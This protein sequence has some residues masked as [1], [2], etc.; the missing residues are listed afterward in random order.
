MKTFIAELAGR[1][2]LLIDGSSLYAVGTCQNSGKYFSFYSSSLKHELVPLGSI[3]SLVRTDELINAKEIYEFKRA[4]IEERTNAGFANNNDREKMLADRKVISFIV[5]ELMP[6]MS[7]HKESVEELLGENT[8]IQTVERTHEFSEEELLA[9]LRLMQEGLKRE[10]AEE[11]QGINPEPI[12]YLLKNILSPSPILML[13]RFVYSLTPSLGEAT[14]KIRVT[15][16]EK[17]WDTKAVTTV[18]NLEKKYLAFL[19]NFHRWKA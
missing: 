15:G 11:F 8:P 1:A 9:E 19:D 13:D 7:G 14:L 18:E 16:E 12:E 17:L 2:P 3:D 6:F 5:K 4:F 10:I